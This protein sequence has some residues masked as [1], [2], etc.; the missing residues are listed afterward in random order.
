ME[1]KDKVVVITGSTKGLG[2]SLATAFA[3]EGA[4]VVMNGKDEGELNQVAKDMNV[5]GVTADVTNE[6]DIARLAEESVKKFG[7][8]D[9]WINN[10]GIWIPHGPIEDI[11]MARAHQMMEVNLFGTMYGS[12]SALAVM[13]KQKSGTIVNILSTSALTGRAGSAAYCASKYA[14]TGFT[15]SLRLETKGSGIEVIA[16]YPGGMQTHL[17]GD[18]QPAD[19]GT[20]MSPDFV[21]D[22]IIKNLRLGNPKEELIIKGPGRSARKEISSTVGLGIILVATG[23]A[24]LAIFHRQAV[25]LGFGGTPRPT[26]PQETA[27]VQTA[28][29]PSLA[30]SSPVTPID[31]A[32]SEAQVTPGLLPQVHLLSPKTA[33]KTTKTAVTTT[34]KPAAAAPTPAPAPPVQKSTAVTAQS[35]LD[36][37][38]LSF[39]E[40]A[41]G[42]YKMVLTTN[43][44]SAGTLTWALGD[45]TIGGSGSLPSFSTDFSCNPIPNLPLQGA[46][47]QNPTFDVRTSYNCSISLTP[48]S[49]ANRAT[50][51]KQ[52][53]FTTPPGAFFVTAPS[54]M[55]T[56]LQSNENDGGFVFRNNDAEPIMVSNLTLD[57]SYTAL[58]VAYGPL[59]LRFI[60]PATELPLGS[61]YH[62]ES[63]AA[64][65]SLPYTNVGTG[66]QIPVSFTIGP[67]SQ[68]L[69]PLELLGVHW[70]SI[71][72][73]NPTMTITLRAVA[74]DQSQGKAVLNA[75]VLSWSCIVATEAYDPNATS[76]AYASGLACQ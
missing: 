33:A 5:F 61:D 51:S 16:I 62:L 49:G 32:S 64:D 66:I 17:F 60:D 43:A 20:Y 39:K 73:V 67:T 34:K 47:D 68:K 55:D 38:T 58:N 59:V 29:A 70:M 10:A 7:R 75:A 11:D 41:D 18:K 27:I 14:E 26:Q 36:A 24:A 1:L 35:F 48:L 46:T 40:E 52:F 21:A 63:L 53:S 54:S 30:S 57:V 6:K 2:R 12:R 19:I 65:P 50:Q 37:T 71:S 22:T 13:R 45:A 56:V 76:G 42:P 3:K 31:T 72:G 28:V 69:L 23:V 44:G 8:I 15:E 4:K 25:L 9:V 74:T